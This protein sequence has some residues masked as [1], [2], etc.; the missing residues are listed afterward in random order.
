AN[1]P[2]YTDL[3]AP[4]KMPGL[5]STKLYPI[6]DAEA[7]GT[8][9]GVTTDGGRGVEMPVAWIYQMRDGTL[10]PASLGT[11]ENPIV[12]RI[13]FWTDDETCKI[14]I[15]TAGTGSGW[16]T[17]HLNS[18]DDIAWRRNQPAAGEYSSY[19]GHPA[20]TS[21]GVVFDALS[22]EALL[23]LTPRYAWGGSLLATQ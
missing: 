10:G 8:V 5:F 11:K 16:N 7:P 2:A 17:P 14:N 6:L 3:N 12:A 22:P 9:E 20:T 15:N 21:L 13:A 19:P 23:R 18:E 1:R 4:V